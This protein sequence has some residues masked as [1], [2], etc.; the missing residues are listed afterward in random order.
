MTAVDGLLRQLAQAYGVAVSYEDN[1]GVQRD[2]DAETVR[3]VLSAF[4]V[5][6]R[7]HADVERALQE[8]TAADLLR[9]LP[10]CTV[11]RAG[12]EPALTV[13][14]P[15]GS[16][17]RMRVLLEDGGELSLQ[18]RA[19]E[20]SARDLAGARVAAVTFSADAELPCGYHRLELDVAGETHTAE[21]IVVPRFLGMP[22]KLGDE[23][24]WGYGVQLYSVPSA[25][26]WGM[27]DLVDLGELAAWSAA[28][29]AQY[30]L[31]N[32]LH[33]PAPTVPVTNSPYSPTS[34]RFVNPI[35]LRPETI[36]EYA[37]L[38]EPTRRHLQEL[39]R[40]AVEH[41]AQF[42]AIDRDVVWRAKV[43][44]LEAVYHAGR[45]AERE[46][47][48]AAFT[49]AEDPLLRDFARWC[50]VAE[51]YGPDDARWPE[52]AHHPGGVAEI[53][54]R[55]P[56][57]VGFHR[58]LQWVAQEQLT[59]A[60]HRAVSAGMRVGI[61]NDLAVG[62]DTRSAEV[63]ADRAHYAAGIS[64]GAPP[65]AYNS[66]GQGWGLAAWRP[67][68]LAESGYRPFRDLVRS[69]LRSSG[70]IRVDHVMGL[71]RLWW[72]P[73]G[74]GPTGGTYVHYDHDAMI[75][76]L[77]LEAS[78]ADALVVGEDLGTVE[79]WVREYLAER[80]VLGTS[81]AWFE[82]DDAG[83]PLP[84][85]MY[86]ELCM[87]SV[88]THDL[89]PTEGYLSGAHLVVRDRLGLLQQPLA[90]EQAELAADLNRWRELL[91]RAGQLRAGEGE[92]ATEDAILALHRFLRASPARVLCAAL[93]D[94]VGD[95]RM[96]NQPGTVDE[97]PNWRVPLT[98]A[99]GA[100]V[101]LEQLRTSARAARLAAVLNGG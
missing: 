65:D 88:T 69:I 48:F 74:A 14:V 33:A 28:Q 53:A 89:A 84:A 76:I 90:R 94:A 79:P 54:D 18:Q 42:D 45:S 5:R 21:L 29:G 93:T 99:R 56:D 38:P 6:V 73:E 64:I 32:P 57:R 41:L 39:R 47:A 8:R 9:P 87:A 11:V 60:Q 68:R 55:D 24:I 37:A 70:G 52:D 22:A 97:Y 58:W 82:R 101:G 10:H 27:G 75:G 77:L 12:E 40:G 15:A 66:L 4:D 25:G 23:R 26:S 50:V 13:D 95:R 46:A 81:V 7:D 1:A 17:V 80:G 96:Q 59:A 91:R 34:R 31:T 78:R 83:A 72:I 35:Y 63:W 100:P 20:G 30:L 92:D 98:D 85:Q 44:A 51:R 43:A 16:A 67:D 2:V 62:V 36:A 3:A 61:V 86:R 19:V 71:F 49:A